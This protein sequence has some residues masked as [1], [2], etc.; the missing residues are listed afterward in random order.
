M[1]GTMER[2][3]SR[4][5]TRKKSKE[6]KDLFLMEKIRNIR[7]ATVSLKGLAGK[8]LEKAKKYNA[9]AIKENA[10]K[11]TS[12]QKEIEQGFEKLKE[13]H[14]NITG[15]PLDKYA[16]GWAVPALMGEEYQQEIKRGG[17]V[18]KKKYAKGGGVRA[19]RF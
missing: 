11:A 2:S 3:V 9:W 13:K 12:K 7:L 1:A 17:S 10:K 6:K 14:K 8:D 15:E 4:A 18:R 19:A 5:K 16:H